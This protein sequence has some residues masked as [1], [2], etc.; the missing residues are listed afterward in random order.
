LEG[1]TIVGVFFSGLEKNRGDFVFML[2][3]EYGFVFMLA[4]GVEGVTDLSWTNAT[5]WVEVLGVTTVAVVVVL[6]VFRPV[7]F[8]GVTGVVVVFVDNGTA[9]AVL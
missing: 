8:L 1:R 7:L 5:F 4:G 6:Q 2:I 3:L 9:E